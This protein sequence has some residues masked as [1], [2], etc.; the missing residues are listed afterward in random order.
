VM[1]NTQFERLFHQSKG[2]IKTKTD[3]DIFPSKIAEAMHKTDLE[4]IRNRKLMEFEEEIPDNGSL[5]HYLSIKFPMFDQNQDVHAVCSVLTDITL[6]KRA[7]E[8]IKIRSDAI[9]DLFNNAPCG[10]HS[11]NRDL[12]II[13][14][15]DTE[16]KWLGYTR[17]EVIGKLSVLDLMT[18]DSKRI[19][20]YHRKKIFAKRYESIQDL[21]LRYKRKD[22]SVFP[23]LLNAVAI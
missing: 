15:N 7:L 8:M 19:A 2:S 18:E 22:G 17:N 16:L 6:R 11:V 10:Y 12:I 21:E 3:R 14:M 13:E 1:I 5:R 4:V 9:M 20:E 23:V